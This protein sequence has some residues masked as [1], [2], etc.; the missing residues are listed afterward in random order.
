MSTRP[1]LTELASE[2]DDLR[3]SD[4][5][6]MAMR[7]TNMN[8]KLLDKVQETHSTEPD[9]WVTY[10][11]RKWLDRDAEA[12]WAKV[13]I[14]LRETE[15]NTLAAK[16]EGKYCAPISEPTPLSQSPHNQSQVT[17]SVATAA[18]T[19][20]SL[21]HSATPSQDQ[22]TCSPVGDSKLSSAEIKNKAASHS[23][24]P[25]S[26]LTSSVA[27]ASLPSLEHIT[28]PSQDEATYSPV[29]EILA[30]KTKVARLRTKFRRVLIHTKICFMD[31]EE[32]SKIF[33]RDFKV[34]LESLPYKKKLK[35]EI[36]NA[37]NVDEI[38]DILEPYYNLVD[39][40]LLEFII[41]EFG[42]SKL[43]EEM[44]KY[45]AEL[46][47]FEKETTV[48]DLSLATQGKEVVPAHYREMAIKLDKD[49]KRFTIHDARQFKK[50]VE[51][52]CE[53]YAFLFRGVSCSSV[54][55]L[56]AFPPEAYAKLSEVISA[57]HFRREHKVVSVVFSEGTA[58]PL[59]KTPKSSL[60]HKGELPLVTCEL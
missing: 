54:E 34:T 60:H 14:A 42:T 30:V 16:L 59:P 46:E 24:S 55:I 35:E 9:L 57:S 26:Q 44:K 21:D 19:E 43:Q 11:M 37:Q 18:S 47:Q 39:Y 23:A 28:M 31:K 15:M 49:P 5:K 7:L 52:S 3:W 50:F 36:K 13:V 29:D 45:V 56:L 10:A 38:F 2:L 48:H 40:D 17:S 27:T 51:M 25:E 32:K 33:L 41:E 1:E 53:E 12:S 4:V 20:S 58:I 6:L 8:L 22:T